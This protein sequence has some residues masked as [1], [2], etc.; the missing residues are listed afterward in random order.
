MTLAGN[1]EHV[2]DEIA[3]LKRFSEST[4]AIEDSGNE[5]K[6]ARLRDIVQREGFGPPRPAI[7]A[8]DRV[9]GHARLPLEPAR[10]L[11]LPR[12]LHPSR[13]EAR[14]AGRAGQQF[15]EGDI[16]V[17]IATEAVG[18]G[19]NLQYCHIFFNYDIPWN[20]NRLEQRMGRIHRYGQRHDCLVFN[21][22]ATN[23][24][25]G[26]V[27]N[28][29]MDRLQEIRDALDDDA[30]FNVVREVLPA[31][32][33]ERVLRDYY[34]ERLGEADLED[35]MLKDVDEGRFRAIC[36]SALDGLAT[37]T[38]NFDMLAERRARAREQRVVPE[39]IARFM[40][41]CAIVNPASGV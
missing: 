7:A 2:H 19:I 20:P 14:F 1:A 16:Q 22:V 25:E 17:L 9:Q 3:E 12:W 15:R 5:A 35:C 41:E 4:R 8:V 40:Q 33:V 31:A 39:S 30:V 24:I 10:G 21:F 29:L 13:H 11:G 32:Q 27:L 23:T 34:A 26:R 28:R 36:R 38:L 6:L 37:R 18:E